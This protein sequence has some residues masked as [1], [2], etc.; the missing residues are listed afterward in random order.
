[1]H[2]SSFPPCP[3]AQINRLVDS[4]ALFALVRQPPISRGTSEG[5]SPIAPESCFCP[6]FL[7]IPRIRSCKRT[8]LFQLCQSLLVSAT[9]QTL[10]LK[11]CGTLALRVFIGQ[12]PQSLTPLYPIPYTT[13]GT[14]HLG[15]KLLSCSRLPTSE[16]QVYLSPSGKLRIAIECW[17]QRD[18]V[19]TWSPSIRHDD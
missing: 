15:V 5:R 4:A 6:P 7:M 14:A 2:H 11:C 9:F 13:L 3:A 12:F 1:M 16:P 19:G 18:R 17:S 8:Q 10:G